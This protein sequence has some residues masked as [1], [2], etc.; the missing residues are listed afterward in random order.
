[1]AQ[2]GFLLIV[3]DATTLSKQFRW[4]ATTNFFLVY[5]KVI[6][7]YCR[8]SKEFNIWYILRQNTAFTI[9]MMVHYSKDI[10]NQDFD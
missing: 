10:I 2:P 8:S 4:L 7:Y 3:G 5:H 1:M 6:A 9:A